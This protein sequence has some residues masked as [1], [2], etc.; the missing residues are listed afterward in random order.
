MAITHAKV[1]TSTTP[2]ALNTASRDWTTLRVTAIT[3][4]LS[5]GTTGVAADTGSVIAIN[6]SETFQLPPGDVLYGVSTGAGAA[7]V[8]R[9]VS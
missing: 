1:V 6:A 2:V 5:V 7:Q 3:T 8:T 4:A 9:I